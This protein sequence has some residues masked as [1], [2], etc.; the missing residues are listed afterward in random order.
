MYYTF[1]S[2]NSKSS[3]LSLQHL[4]LT[5]DNRLN[6]L[7]PDQDGQNVAPD[8]GP[9]HLFLHGNSLREAV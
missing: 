6:S 3:T 7:D 2:K 9:N 1:T 5:A 8:L 4:L